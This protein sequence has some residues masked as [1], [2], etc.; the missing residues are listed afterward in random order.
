[1]NKI[2]KFYKLDNEGLGYNPMYKFN[3]VEELRTAVQFK[4]DVPNETDI[5]AETWIDDNM[6]IVCLNILEP[7]SLL[8]NKKTKFVLSKIFCLFFWLSN[9]TFSIIFSLKLYKL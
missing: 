5:I 1:M 9:K 4:K 3:S 2:I 7:K 8:L 6:I